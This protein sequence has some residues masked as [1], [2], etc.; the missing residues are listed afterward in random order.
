MAHRSTPDRRRRGALGQG[1]LARAPRRT[2][3]TPSRHPASSRSTPRRGAARRTRT[4]SAGA[5]GR[6][7]TSSTCTRAPA[8]SRS[9]S[10]PRR[11]SSAVEAAG[12]A[13][14]D[15]RRNLETAQLD[16]EVAPATRPR[17]PGARRASTSRSSTRRAQG[18]RHAF[19]Q[20]LA[21]ARPRAIAYV[22]CD[23]ATLARDVEALCAGGLRARRRHRRSTCS[24]RR[25]TSR[26]SRS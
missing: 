2:T 21:A 18:S 5:L 14:R 20:A 10:P 11:G 12:S 26:R 24:R 7:T 25:A 19:S 13:V 6:R 17:A 1:V 3:R 4:R 16:A 15:L 8:P 22:S 23:P 9:R